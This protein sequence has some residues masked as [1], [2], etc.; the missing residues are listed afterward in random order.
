MLSKLPP[1]SSSSHSFSVD[2]EVKNK[3]G[4]GTFSEVWL[5]V[6]RNSG[7]EFAA[8]I[9]KKNYGETIDAT[10]WDDISEVNVLNAVGHHPFLLKMVEAHHE[11]QTGRIILITELMKKS[12]YDIIEVGECPLSDYRVK[13]YMYQMLE[14]RYITL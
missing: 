1:Y 3:I 5:C 13:I 14:G 9:L 6:Q 10:M 12:L 4:E 7:Q 2:Y 8:K 11:R